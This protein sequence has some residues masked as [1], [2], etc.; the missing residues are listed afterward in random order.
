LQLPLQVAA[1][2]DVELVTRPGEVTV[3][4]AVC[5]HPLASV[6]VTVYPPAASPVA[7]EPVCP[8]GFQEYVYGDVPPEAVTLALPFAWLQVEMAEEV[9]NVMPVGWVTVTEAVD[10]QPFASVTVTV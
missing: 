6:I 5:E 2:E 1:A 10:V 7:V 9:V 8:D 4:E 3:T